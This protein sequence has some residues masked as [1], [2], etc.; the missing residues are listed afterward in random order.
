LWSKTFP[1]SIFEYQF[2]DDRIAAMYNR[3]ENM[4]KA[5]QLFSAIAIFIGCLGLYGLIS[6]VA[7]QKVKEIGIRKVL[8]A[9]TINIVNLFSSEY[10]LLILVSFLIA[11]P[12]AF[13]A[14]NNWLQNFA[15]HIDIGWGVFAIAALASFVIAAITVSYRS[16]RAAVANPVKS[17]RME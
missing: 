11:G 17:L 15:Y 10:F 8:G 9:S 4:Y 3:E 12:I 13:Y 7:L 2:L 14:M 5:F 16:I 6:F 1:E